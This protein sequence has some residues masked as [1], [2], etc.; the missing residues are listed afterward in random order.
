[1]SQYILNLMPDSGRK[2]WTLKWFASIIQI[3]GY[4]ATGFGYTPLN[5]YLFLVG[6]IGWFGVGL[7]WQDK[8]I[9]LIHIIALAAM[10][11]GMLI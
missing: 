6:L 7:L 8:A 11:Y 4:S 5:Q 3:M 1:M 9:I 2:T 10:T